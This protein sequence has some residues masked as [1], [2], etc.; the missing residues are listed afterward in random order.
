MKL[1]RIKEEKKVSFNIERKKEKESIN[2]NPLES[3]HGERGWI[4]KGIY[5]PHE[6][7]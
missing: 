2:K 3:L 4:L 5:I 6:G 7:K 1:I